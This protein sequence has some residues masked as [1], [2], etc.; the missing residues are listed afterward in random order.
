MLKQLLNWN[1]GRI[2]PTQTEEILDK[3][4]KVVQMQRNGFG[5]QVFRVSNSVFRKGCWAEIS[6]LCS[7]IHDVRP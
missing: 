3:E 4:S 7:I 5:M 1:L 6:G 2:Y